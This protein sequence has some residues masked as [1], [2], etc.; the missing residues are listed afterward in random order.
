MLRRRPDVRLHRRESDI[1]AMGAQQRRILA[2]LWPLLAPGGRL[3]YVTCSLLDE[4]G[5]GQADAFLAAHPDWHAD[6]P[7]LPLGGPRGP[8]VRLT[9][10]HDGTDGFFI[11]RL[12]KA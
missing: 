9:P 12:G 5:A 3:V 8:G 4:E 1:A 2:A 11:A 10:F 7:H 6:P